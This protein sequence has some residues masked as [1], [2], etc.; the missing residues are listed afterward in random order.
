MGG[1]SKGGSS[2]GPSIDPTAA[3]STYQ[4]WYDRG[5]QGW[6]F[7]PEGENLPPEYQAYAAQGYQAG[8][9]EFQAQNMM[10]QFAA[11]FGMP[12]FPM[13]EG[14]SY[15]EQMADQQRMMGEQ[16]R[17]ELFSQYMSTAGQAADYVNAEIADE[18]A[19]AK[20][21][22][23]DYEINDEQKQQRINNY[24]ATMWGEGDQSRLEALM[25]EWGNPEGFEGFT[26]V[27]GDPSAYSKGT[28][29]KEKTVA[30][31]AP[32]KPSLLS[33]DEDILGGGATVLGGA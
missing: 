14:P 7:N 26:V 20:L 16:N 17:D 11:G 33:T 1:G 31:S 4:R 9:Q 28:Q 15:E 5:T 2:S 3:R 19:Q 18:M 21:S 10:N 23:V 12:E 27:R 22:G 30:T 25:G 32:I 29:G 13:P 6:K 8:Q 24:F